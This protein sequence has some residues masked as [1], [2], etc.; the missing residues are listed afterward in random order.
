MK[1]RTEDNILTPISI[2]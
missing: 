1:H 2:Y